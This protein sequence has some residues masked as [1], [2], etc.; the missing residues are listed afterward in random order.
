MTPWMGP[1]GER[2]LPPVLVDAASHA[3]THLS[4]LGTYAPQFLTNM[5]LTP[6]P[7]HFSLLSADNRKSKPWDQQMSDRTD[8]AYFYPA[9][10]ISWEILQGRLWHRGMFPSEVLALM[11]T[12]EQSLM[13]T[14][15]PVSLWMTAKINNNNLKELCALWSHSLKIQTRSCY[16]V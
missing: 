12:E 5:A 16:Y 15:L 4:P 11:W 2:G 8:Q 10:K 3:H 7:L 9:I 6:S 14:L 13:Q 1:S